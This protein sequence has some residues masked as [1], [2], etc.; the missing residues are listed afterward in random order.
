MKIVYIVARLLLGLM[1]FVLGLNGFLN[2]LQAPP[3][4]GPAGQFLT[5]LIDTHFVWFTCGVQV[6]AGAMLLT[7][8][9]VPLAIVTLAAV[10]ANILAYH[11]LMQPSGLPLA[12]VALVLWF[13]VAWPLRGHFAPLFTRS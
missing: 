10:L 6:I 12:L 8:Q 13:I 7:G 9:F 1:F 3:I 4:P 11:I 5:A 2:F